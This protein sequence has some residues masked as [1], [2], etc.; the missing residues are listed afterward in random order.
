M[1]GKSHSK[2]ILIIQSYLNYMYAREAPIDA[3]ISICFE[4]N[5]G[6]IDGDSASSTEL[7]AIISTLSGISFLTSLFS[8]TQYNTIQQ[9]RVF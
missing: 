9:F 2:G 5:Y 8:P 7:Y 3:A 6:M 1:S 4:Q